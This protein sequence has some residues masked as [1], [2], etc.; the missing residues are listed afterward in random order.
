MFNL[1]RMDLRR[2]VRTRSFYIVLAVTAEFLLLMILMVAAVSD[3]E[4]MDALTSSGVV[5]VGGDSQD[6]EEEL[7]GMTQLDFVHNCLGSG[8]LLMVTCIGMALFTNSDFSSGYVKN[9][10]FARPRRRDYVLSKV[11]VGGAYSGMLVIAGV[12]ISLVCPILF[13]L[14][15]ETSPITLI[16]QYAFWMW[17]PNWA[18]GLM[19]LALVLLTR[20]STLGIILAV[21]SGGGL[22]A[23]LVQNLCQTFG[24]PNLAQYMLSMVVGSQ[25]VP[26]PG[27]EQMNMVLG[28]CCLVG[29]SLPRRKPGD[30][31]EARHLRRNSH[32]ACPDPGPCRPGDCPV[33][34]GVLPPPNA[35]DGPRFG[36]DPNRE[37]PAFDSAYVRRGA[38]AAV[39]G[40]E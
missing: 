4:K 8:L 11:L 7:L 1:L 24:W 20:S 3:P 35:G 37:Q 28:L 19:G 17:L 26:M 14:R 32:A 22:T 25:C 10:C 27:M 16:L 9:I 38:P 6:L 18:F 30:D 34:S 5:V 2:L 40:G 36:G 12:L 33:A 31:G 21:V 29:G 13:G 39:P 23:V 15:L